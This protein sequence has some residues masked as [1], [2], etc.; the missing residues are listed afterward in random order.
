MQ[1][2]LTGGSGF[3]GK[4]LIGALKSAGI[5][6]KLFEDD[7]CDRKI[8]LNFRASEK[9]DAVIHLAGLISGKKTADFWTVNVN[10]TKNIADLAY[11]LKAKLLFLSSL[12]VISSLDNPPI[13]IYLPFHLAS[14]FF[15]NNLGRN[16]SKFLLSSRT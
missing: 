13:L 12:R 1:V 2:L 15:S 16:F 4:N 10:G 3:I 7:L 6:V 5:S 9:I 11:R 8:V 14:A